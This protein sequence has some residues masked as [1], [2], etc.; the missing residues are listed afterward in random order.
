M[1]LQFKLTIPIVI[2]AILYVAMIHVLWVPHQYAKVEA[3]VVSQ[4]NSQFQAMDTGLIRNMLENDYAALH[5]TLNEQLRLH[6]D[7]WH[8]LSLHDIRGKKLYP[9]GELEKIPHDHEHYFPFT[10]SIELEDKEFGQVHLHVDWKKQFDREQKQIRKLEIYLIL[11]VLLFIIFILYW[12]RRIIL[13]PIFNLQR[14]T[15]ELSRGDYSYPLSDNSKDEFGQLSHSFS[16][17]RSEILWA[18]RQLEQAHQ[19]VKE[20]L[21]EVTRKN[22]ELNAEIEHRKQI[23]KQLEEMATHDELTRLPNRYLLKQEALKCIALAQRYRQKVGIMFVDLDRFKA[24][25]DNHGHETGDMVL[26]EISQR[27]HG[28]VRQVDTVG[29]VGGDEFIIILPDCGTFNDVNEIAQRILRR[30]NQ[31]IEAVQIPQ[32]VGASIGISMY[33]DDGEDIE[34][35]LNKADSAM[36]EV[37]QSRKNSGESVSQS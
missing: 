18:H 37:K 7:R 31:P 36:Y 30:V 35:L 5:A 19:E 11:I 21:E 6:Q 32:T 24:V 15:H 25:N 28:E 26:V 9:L 8:Y 1:N 29:R 16:A 12:Q 33:P 13:T 27:L 3:Q 14:A 22:I 10:H 4:L 23:E 17:M 34:Q 20:S 2:S